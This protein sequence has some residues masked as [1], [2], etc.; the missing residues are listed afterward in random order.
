MTPPPRPWVVTTQAELSEAAAAALTRLG[1]RQVMVLDSPDAW[2]EFDRELSDEPPDL[3]IAVG[4][5]GTVQGV[6][7][8]LGANADAT[9]GIVPLGTGNDF[10]RA[11]GLPQDPEA[12]V[13]VILKGATRPVDLLSLARDENAD[14]SGGGGF[15]RE[16]V[17]NAVT[18]GLSGA[19]DTELDDETKARWG[20]FAYL[21]GAL[22]G[23]SGLDAF[24]A[25]IEVADEP[26]GELRLLHEGDLL[27][28]SLANG[29][30]AGGGVPIAPDAEVDDGLLDVCGV[31]DATALEIG[32]QVPAVL[33]GGEAGEPWVLAAVA[34][35]RL[36]LDVPHPVSVD[37]EVS[38]ARLLDIEVVCRA[39][40]VLTPD[41]G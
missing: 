24:R 23:A 17:V 26:G 27:H 33:T 15:D 10:A 38:D 8:A 16:L 28:V 3:V 34:R 13:D 21:R 4:G 40:E 29:P 1:S 31:T 25:R 20:R 41:G 9:L 2:Q 37:G 18:V 36:V 22:K 32:A 35:A 11:L 5:D 14:P 7:R 39:L 30:N 19:I 6:V 12:A